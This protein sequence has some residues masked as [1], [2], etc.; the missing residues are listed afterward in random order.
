[1]KKSRNLDKLLPTLTIIIFISIITLLIELN[2]IPKQIIPPPNIIFETFI[3][4][5]PLMGKEMLYTLKMSIMGLLLS[6]MLGCTLSVLMDNYQLIR[7]ALLPIFVIFQT[8]P[9]IAIAPVFVLWFGY[10]EFT[11]IIVI[12]LVCV[13]PITISFLQGLQAVDQDMIDLLRSMGANNYRTFLYVKLPSSLSSLFAG[14]KISGA[15]CVMSS[16]I[17]EW[18]G[19]NDGIGV[20]MIRVKK[21]YA[22]D[23]MFSAIILI[24]AAS[25]VI[26]KLISL[27]EKLLIRRERTE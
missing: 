7:K 22:Y 18:L 3:E 12:I 23:K 1:M 20:Y 14:L 19:G 8:I 9:M 16:V 27:T 21:N 11:K 6:I 5:F 17:A 4:T 2:I 13:F 10:G 15:Y 25:L 24:V 26:T